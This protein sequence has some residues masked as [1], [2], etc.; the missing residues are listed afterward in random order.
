MLSLTS[1]SPVSLSY[2][3]LFPS[4]SSDVGAASVFSWPCWPW[5][6]S[7]PS[8]FLLFLAR[9]SS[10]KAGVHWVH[11]RHK[12]QR[13]KTKPSKFTHLKRHVR[14]TK[15]QDSR[16]NPAHLQ[17]LERRAPLWIF[18]QTSPR[19][20]HRGEHARMHTPVVSNSCWGKKSVMS[21]PMLDALFQKQD[22][23]QNYRLNYG[24]I[25]STMCSV[26][27]QYSAVET[28]YVCLGL[29]W[30]GICICNRYLSVRDD[31]WM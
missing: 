4:D 3:S 18:K 24:Y 21:E 15:D 16:C 17:S 22:C 20:T 28:I 25:L 7:L 26:M 8:S 31:C 14:T 12:K 11:S 27:C 1:F 2:L 10:A 6:V 29:K 19:Q 30:K 13:W 9:V 23:F 5:A